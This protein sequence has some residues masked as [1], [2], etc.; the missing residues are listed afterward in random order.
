MNAKKCVSNMNR[1]PMTVNTV[2]KQLKEQ[3]GFAIAGALFLIVV[4]ALMGSV[5][6]RLVSD[7]SIQ[8]VQDIEN[9]KALNVARAGVEFALYQSNRNNVCGSSSLTVPDIPGFRV[10]LTCS[11]TLTTEAGISYAIDTWT[12]TACNRSAC[13]ASVDAGYVERQVVAQIVVNN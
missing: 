3:S 9:A 4:L 13:P 10:D 11:R 2:K 7:N 1:K 8:T 5:V 12:A 6:W